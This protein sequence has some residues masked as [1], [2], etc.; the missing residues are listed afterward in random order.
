MLK[1]VVTALTASEQGTEINGPDDVRPGDLLQ[2]WTT[3][4]LHSTG[5]TTIIHTVNTSAGP[6]TQGMGPE[7][8]PGPVTVESVH[9]L[10]SQRKLAPMGAEA[11]ADADERD[12]KER[13]G[14]DHLYVTGAIRLD[15]GGGG[16]LLA[17]GTELAAWWAVR[18]TGSAWAENPI[19]L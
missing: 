11:D 3:G 7:Q 13:D 1:G 10:G 4:G 9:V 6:L 19:A 2:W 15:A 12:L 16:E 18:P 17:E 14:E 8:V 5:H